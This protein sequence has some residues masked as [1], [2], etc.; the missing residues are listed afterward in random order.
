MDVLI[1]TYASITFTALELAPD[2]NPIHF[3]AK[4]SRMRREFVE[5]AN[6]VDPKSP[7]REMAVA[8]LAT[9]S[10]S[11]SAER[12]FSSM[13]QYPFSVGLCMYS[14]DLYVCI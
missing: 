9:P 10:S 11:A 3:W 14:V 13:G 2:Y 6:V 12:I 1:R 8:I 7:L 5:V 4:N